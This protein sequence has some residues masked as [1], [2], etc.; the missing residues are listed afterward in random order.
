LELGLGEEEYWIGIKVRKGKY[1]IGTQ[2]RRIGKLHW[3][4][5]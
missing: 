1:S 5:V 3:K 2:V 4:Q